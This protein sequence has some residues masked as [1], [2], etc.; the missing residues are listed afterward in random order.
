MKLL[1]KA[2]CHS[3]GFH[4]IRSTVY[5]FLQQ[6]PWHWSWTERNTYRN[7]RLDVWRDALRSNRD[8]AA[9]RRHCWRTDSCSRC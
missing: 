5:F 7:R 9:D 3:R 6:Q 1:F 4:R 8:T 2:N